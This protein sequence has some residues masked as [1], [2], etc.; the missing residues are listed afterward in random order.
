M[1]ISVG[2][3][4]LSREEYYF[5]YIISNLYTDCLVNNFDFYVLDFAID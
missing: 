3:F 1:T 5:C 4:L 2:D